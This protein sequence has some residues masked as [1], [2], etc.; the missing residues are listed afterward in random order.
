MYEIYNENLQL[1]MYNNTM[2]RSKDRLLYH[3]PKIILNQLDMST[4]K[5][6][7]KEMF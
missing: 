2:K 4:I 5:Y 6:F 1:T 7:R 3:S